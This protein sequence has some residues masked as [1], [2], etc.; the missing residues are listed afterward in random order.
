MPSPDLLPKGRSY[1]SVVAPPLDGVLSSA[2]RR[3]TRRAGLVGVVAAAAVSATAFAFV[4]HGSSASLHVVTPTVPDHST[5]PSPAAHTSTTGVVRRDPTTT[6]KPTGTGQGSTAQTTT[7]TTTT[8]NTDQDATGHA[9][10]PAEQ[11]G[12]PDQATAVRRIVGPPHRTTQYDPTQACAGTG[13]TV[14]QGWCSYYDGATSGKA[15]QSVTLST[16]VCRLPGQG[17]GTLS[18]RTGR[19]ADFAVGKNTYRPVWRWSHG[20]YFTQAPTSIRVP[21]G[22]CVEWYVSWRVVDNA[23]RRLAPGSYYLAAA[24]RM[25][26][27]SKTASA[28]A[29]NPITFTVR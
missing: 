3:R 28:T 20:R 4:P 2:R 1:P 10:A 24:P 6:T 23:G 29:T 5:S 27:A 8:G 9:A 21:A 13:P 19:Q 15:G 18:S 7:Q 12:S 17:T 16:A 14:A 22:T 26:D 11:P 25:G